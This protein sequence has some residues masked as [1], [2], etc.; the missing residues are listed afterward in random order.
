MTRENVVGE[1]AYYLNS[2]RTASVVADEPSV[3]F[4]LDRPAIQKLAL[5]DPRGHALLH[6]LLAR[7]IAERVAHLTSA[8]RALR[9]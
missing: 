2:K 3:L 9:R 8:V 1:I 7:L 5:E 6:E 4:R